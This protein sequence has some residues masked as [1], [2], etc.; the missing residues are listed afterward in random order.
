[1]RNKCEASSIFIMSRVSLKKVNTRMSQKVFIAL[2]L[3]LLLISAAAYAATSQPVAVTTFACSGNKLQR[4]GPCPHGGEPSFLIQGSDSNFYGT[5]FVS[6][7]GN[8]SQPNGGTVFSVTPSGQ[9]TLLH[10]FLPGVKNNY[11]NGNNPG[12][13]TEG[14]DGNFYGVTFNGGVPGHGVLYRVG[15]KA[16]FKVI[17]QFCSARNCTD[18]YLNSSLVSGSDGNLYGLTIAGGTGNCFAGC[19]TIFR[20]VPATGIY[21]V[22]FNFDGKADGDHPI[23]LTLARDGSFYGFSGAIFHYVPATGDFQLLPGTT[24]PSFGNDGSFPTGSMVIANGK[25]YGLY[26]IYQRGG[27]GLFE[28]NLDGTNLNLFPR[29]NTTVSGGSPSGVLLA[30]DGNLWVAEHVANNFN[31]DLI[32]LSLSAG[33]VLK[34]LKPFGI[35]AAVGALPSALLQVK[36]GTLWGTTTMFGKVSAGHFG[37][38]VVYSLN[39]GLPPR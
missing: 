6:S 26:T 13:I 23:S 14:S 4:V 31:G 39:A 19:G 18:G 15:R 16:G 37:D 29:Y 20:V 22:V 36:D 10:T 38:G 3:A 2:S 7:E 12:P 8:Q 27:A 35:N 32:A 5:T 17:H 33:T 24:F 11:P 21:E 28:V 25:I 30:S 9:F 1:M 34:T